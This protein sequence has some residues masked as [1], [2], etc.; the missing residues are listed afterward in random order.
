MLYEVITFYDLTKKKAIFKIE[1]TGQEV[2]DG[3]FI[4]G[5]FNDKQVYDTFPMANEGNGIYSYFTFLNENDSG[6]YFFS[7]GNEI[8]KVK[9]SIPANCA[10]WQ[11]ENRFYR[12]NFV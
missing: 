8:P 2:S 4:S 11:N 6:G 7:T 1:M 12:N 9:E 5:N 10:D 3:V